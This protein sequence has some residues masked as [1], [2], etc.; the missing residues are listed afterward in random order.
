ME[1]I[2]KFLN[3]ISSSMYI[4]VIGGGRIG[5]HLVSMLMEEGHDIALI[6]KDEEKAKH[7]A[8]NY[9]ILVIKGDGGEAKY[10]EDAGIHKADVL[11][12]CTGNDQINFV[13]CQ[14]AKSTYNVPK[15]IARTTNPSNKILYEKL[16]VDV[17]VSTTEAAAK[18]IYAGI[19]GFSAVLMFSGDIELLYA[20]I[21]ERSPLI[22]RKMSEIHMPWGSII[23]AILRGGNI[24]VPSEE[25]IILP[26]DEVVIV[27]KKIAEK[28]IRDMIVGK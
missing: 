18:A 24:V 4:I 13:A 15:V 12:A 26:D 6:E 14:L 9:D 10:L 3:S 17:V 11:V 21:N 1:Q 19:K 20:K 27:A 8:E 16:G 22:K 25:E 5:E 28:K 23:A 7:M 2:F